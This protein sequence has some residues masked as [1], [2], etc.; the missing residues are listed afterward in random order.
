MASPDTNAK[1]G[2]PVDVQVVCLERDALEPCQDRPNFAEMKNLHSKDAIFSRL[3]L[4]DGVNLSEN[5]PLRERLWK[6]M[7]SYSRWLARRCRDRHTNMHFISDG[8]LAIFH[9]SV[10][11]T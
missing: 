6:K 10:E 7:P 3:R 2:A 9:V 1:A 8:A 4:V 5:Q 11:K